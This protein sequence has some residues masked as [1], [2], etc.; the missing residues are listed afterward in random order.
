MR[1]LLQK[2]VLTVLICLCVCVGVLK[3]RDISANAEG[4]Y[5]PITQCEL[6]VTAFEEKIS[7]I[8]ITLTY[9]KGKL[10]QFNKGLINY[11]S[12]INFYDSE[13][14]VT[15]NKLSVTQFIPESPSQIKLVISKEDKN[16]EIG[17]PSLT[18]GIIHLSVGTKVTYVAE[19][20]GCVGIEFP[21]GLTLYASNGT[22]P[23]T[24]ENGEEPE[25]YLNVAR[26]DVSFFYSETERSLVAVMNVGHEPKTDCTFETAITLVVDGEEVKEKIK[27]VQFASENHVRCTLPKISDNAMTIT[28][29]SGTLTHAKNKITYTLLESLT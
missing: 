6:T 7:N 20:E 14:I 29:Q 21:E 3:T 10:P 4:T 17:Y 9:A 22:L 1:K 2:I 27:A 12:E 13:D 23:W 19:D 5:L 16:G 15:A 28:I 24:T 8:S 26:N 25:V 11:L 18:T